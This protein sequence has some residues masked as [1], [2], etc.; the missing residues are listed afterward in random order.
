MRPSTLRFVIRNVDLSLALETSWI[1]TYARTTYLQPLVPEI[2]AG[3]VRELGDAQR[4]MARSAVLRTPWRVCIGLMK[5]LR[6][7]R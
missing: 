3:V 5:R 6:H 2:I 7:S 4:S 1:K